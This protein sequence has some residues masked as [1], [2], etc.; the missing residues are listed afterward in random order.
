VTQAI[1]LNDALTA[2]N[3]LGRRFNADVLLIE[4]LGGGWNKADLASDKFVGQKQYKG[5]P[6]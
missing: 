3:V 4:A 5:F 6:W 2:V 1:A